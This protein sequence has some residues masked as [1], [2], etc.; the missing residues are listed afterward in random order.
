MFISLVNNNYN[1]IQQNPTI[2]TVRKNIYETKETN[3]NNSPNAQYSRISFTGVKEIS[4]VE[5]KNN[6]RADNYKGCLLGG[7]IGD[8]LGAPIEFMNMSQIKKFYGENGVNDLQTGICGVAE[9]SDDTQMMIF[10]ADGLIKS[11]GTRFKGNEIPDMN[12]VYDSYLDWLETQKNN[13][14]TQKSNKGWIS[15]ISG[16]YE[17]RNPG[18]TCLSALKSGEMGTLSK[19]INNSKGNG[20]V[21]R[22]APVGLLYF[23]N[24]K[25]AFEVGSRCAAITHGHPSGYLSAGV[26]SS[27]LAYIIKGENI[28]NAVDKSIEI[29]EKHSNHEEV[30]EALLKA[31]ALAKTNIPPQEAIESIGG[32]WVGEEAVAI[33]V[34][35]ALK[36]PDNYENAVKMAVNHSG[37]S[38]STGSIT[39]NIIGLSLGENAIPEKWREK[40]EL[41]NELRTISSDLYAAPFRLQKLRKRY[42]YNMGRVPNWYDSQKN[43]QNASRLQ[44]VRFSPKDEAKMQSMSAKDLI[45]FKKYLIRNKLYH[46]E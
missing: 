21:M 40:L 14:T 15:K 9:I 29:L 36:S 12:I 28:E 23:N 1:R 10:T 43:P 24:P 45:E 38:D 25:I 18:D 20:G 41:V 27:I 33:A 19:P 6:H 31:K 2:N 22:V 5:K 3:L 16:L 42:P 32:G 30:K 8:A 46:V 34:Y 13:G 35:C 26:L 4:K 17:Q 11:I 44:Y 39:G 7:A 37:D